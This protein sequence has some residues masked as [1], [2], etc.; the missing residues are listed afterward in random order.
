MRGA[1]NPAKSGGFRQLGRRSLGVSLPLLGWAGGVLG[2][3]LERCAYLD[4][5]TPRRKRGV[6]EGGKRTLAVSVT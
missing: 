2:K 1:G 5:L 6:R 3:I 4:T